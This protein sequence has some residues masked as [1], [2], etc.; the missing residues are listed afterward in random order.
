MITGAQLYTLRDFCKTPEQLAETLKRVADMGYRTVQ[1]SGTCAYD[2]DWM[3]E[4][5]RENGLKCVLTHTDAMRIAS[6]TQDVV[7]DHK[8]FGCGHIG[9]GYY[10]METQEA[11][12]EFLNRFGPAM[13]ILEE[14]GMKL[15]YHNHDHEFMHINGRTVLM[16][17]AERTEENR[18][19]FTLDTF[20]VQAGGGDA[21]WWL[22][23]LKGRVPCVHFKDMG[24]GRKMLP[25]GGGN[26]NFDEI[27]KACEYAGVKYA[28][29]EQ[30]DCNG[31]DPFECMKES[32]E[33]LKSCGIKGE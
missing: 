5:L 10:K 25:V 1:L 16:Q 8:K 31:R 13:K 30:D 7:N 3:N 22:R 21:A 18:L 23:Y 11:V 29:V 14:N 24:Y 17:L 32:F 6:H 33:Y 27:I 2:P 28:L 4:R 19:G 9:I 15:M 12:D 26:M 20:W